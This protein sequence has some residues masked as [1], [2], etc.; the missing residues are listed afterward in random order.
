MPIVK[1]K[2]GNQRIFPPV[3]EMRQKQPARAGFVLFSPDR[4][5][6]F[7]AMPGYFL[8]DDAGACAGAPTAG[9]GAVFAPPDAGAVTIFIWPGDGVPTIA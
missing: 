5:D 3:S 2:K 8:P 1:I 7:F 9:A 4:K 6:V